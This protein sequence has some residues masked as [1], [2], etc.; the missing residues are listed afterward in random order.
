MRAGIGLRARH[1]D[2]IVQHA[3]AVGFLEIH[4]ENYLAGGPA[5]RKVER[6]R[7]DHALSVHGVGL[8][9]GSAEGL[10]ATHLA[11]VAALVERLQPAFV[12]EHLA[13]SRVGG[14]YLN[15]LLPLPYTEESLGVVT[16]NVERLQMALRRP[17]MIENPASY[18]AFVHSTIPEPEFLAALATRTGC[19]L[20]CDINN[21]YVSA[22]NL[23]FEPGGYLEALPAVAIGEFHLAGHAR[24]DV[25]GETVLIDDHGSL[26]CEAVWTLY[27]D[28]VARLGSR[29]T[30]VEWD[31]GVPELD[32]LL[33]E[34]SRAD[35]EASR[36]MQA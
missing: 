8:S 15:D 26:I 28:A 14:T 32:V 33:G 13:W 5:L 10:D 16:R 19:E 25:D 31:T 7:R 36:A 17:V 18:L 6:L 12:S 35:R 23:G 20:L 34:A 24:K 11:R 21:I 1:L 9:L 3:G 4:A 29:P 30:L 2:E 27:R 22:E